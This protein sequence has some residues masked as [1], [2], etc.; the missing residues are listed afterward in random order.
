MIDCSDCGGDSCSGTGTPSAARRLPCGR[1]DHQAL[2]ALLP[3]ELAFEPVELLLQGRNFGTELLR[4]LGHLCRELRIDSFE[5]GDAR[6]GVQERKILHQIRA[7]IIPEHIT[8]CRDAIA[9]SASFY[10][11]INAFEQREKLG[12]AQHALH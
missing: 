7:V 4:C 10:L 12:G 8:S 9:F 11:D 1:I 6:R 2:L 3:E 5:F